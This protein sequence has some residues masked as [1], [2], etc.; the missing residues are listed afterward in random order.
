MAVVILDSVLENVYYVEDFDPEAPSAPTCYAFGRD[1]KTIAPHGEVEKPQCA[2]CVDCEWNKWASSARG[3]G[4]ACRNRRRLAVIPAGTL[5]AAGRFTAFNEPEAYEAQQVVYLAL[6]PTSINGFGGFVK[7]VAGALQRPPHGIFTKVKL[8][9]DNK[10]QFKVTFEALGPVPRELLP[11]VMKRHT[12]VQQVIEFPYA[13]KT[14]VPVAKPK[15]KPK[16]RKY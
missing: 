7:Q 11:V 4:K 9:P 13:A 2:S 5:D 8:V 15:G 1:E 16:A 14:E 3:R 12:E 10:T 6:P